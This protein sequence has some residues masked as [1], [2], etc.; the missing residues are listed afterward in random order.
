VLDLNHILLFVAC[1]SP[2][3]LLAQGWRHGG[4]DRAWR[5]AAL[6]VL[7]VTGI[8][9]IL[10]PDVAGFMGGGA[11]LVLILIPSFGLRK[12]AELS[13][14]QRYGTAGWLARILRF[15]HP[16]DRLRQQS[17]LLNAFQ[18][19]QQGHFD[20]ALNLLDSLAN[21]ESQVGRQAIAQ[22]FRIRS[23]WSGLLQW[24]RT[25]LPPVIRQTD[26]ALQPLYLRALGETGARDEMVLDYNTNA[27]RM[28]S[29][30]QNP[31]LYDLALL[32][33]LAFGGRHRAVSKLF[34]ARLRKLSHDAK[35]FWI[36][37]SQFAAGETM[38]GRT[39]LQN[40]LTTTE[41]GV[42]RSEST[43]RLDRINQFSRSALSPA[44]E[45]LLWRI[46][47]AYQ[48]SARRSVL[49]TR[50]PTIMVMVF[51]ALNLAMFVA[52]CALGGSTNPVTLHQLGALEFFRIRFAGEYW[53]LFTSL[54][55]HYGVLHLLFNLY[56]LF[57]IGPGLE[58]AI[59]SI[60]FAICYLTSGLGSGIGVLLLHP[61]VL[62]GVEQLV[63]ASGCVM[64][65]VGVWAGLLLRHRHTPNAGR[66]LKNILLIV[67]V[68]TAFDLST[69]QIS[70]AAHMSGL[71][72]GLVL[73]LLLAPRTLQSRDL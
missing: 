46:E 73:G 10:T 35:E 53:R 12:I 69:P 37:V 29:T 19:A 65:L 25:D 39:R 24:F 62:K 7:L 27:R 42:I 48:S 57:I 30:P 58:R 31:W 34:E 5:I 32:P 68:Q 50:R 52:E 20:E 21:N 55:L 70:M 15:L 9:W 26:L 59:G 47:Q 6:S 45:A 40:L 28:G 8:F 16:A 60:R 36:G 43:Y 22:S 71:L 54:F 61:F 49:E 23:D 41:D 64:G 67:A 66:R 2:L 13:A 51:I 14:R 11:W 17:E 38:A 18:F 63:G 44:T 33:V 72:T 1:V 4:M 56:A 3:V